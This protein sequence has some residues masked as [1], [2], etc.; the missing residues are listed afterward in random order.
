MLLRMIVSTDEAVTDIVE[1]ECARADLFVRFV[2]R[3]LA[4]A[5]RAGTKVT[6]RLERVAPPPH[7]EVLSEREWTVP[8]TYRG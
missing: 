4:S 6:L 1:Q 7:N 5:A 2:K 3:L 8:A